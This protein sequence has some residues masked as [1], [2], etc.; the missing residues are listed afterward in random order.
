MKQRIVT[1]QGIRSKAFLPLAI[2][3]FMWLYV[4][5]VNFVRIFTGGEKLPHIKTCNHWSVIFKE[6]NIEFEAIAKGV[7][8]VEYSI[9]KHKYVKEW[10]FCVENAEPAF[11]YCRQQKG[12]GYEILNFVF[13][14]L[15]VAGFRWLGPWNDRH[16]SCVELANRV[17]QIIGVEE[18]NKFD[19]PYQ[20]QVKLEKLFGGTV[21]KP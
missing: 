4:A 12:K 18:I 16:H 11:L 1:I 2:Q 3:F 17:L 8:E 9:E 19:N 13:H 7:V 10:D 20:T 14:I 15:K 5:R 6:L 21:V